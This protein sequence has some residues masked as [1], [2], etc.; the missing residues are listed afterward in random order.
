MKA[1]S[2]PSLILITF[3]SFIL[4]SCSKEPNNGPRDGI[5]NKNLSGFILHQYTSEVKKLD[6]VTGKESNFFSYNSY[7]AVGWD[8]SRDGTVRI[9]A[10]REPGVF[11]RTRMRLV[12]VA[13]G[14]IIKDFDYDPKYGTSTSNMGELSFDKT[15][16]LIEPDFDNGIVIIN[17]DGE[18]LSRLDGINNQSFT[19]YDKVT[20]LPNNGILIRFDDRF[21]L[22]ADPPYNSL[23]L[24]KEMNYESWGNLRVSND[25]TKVSMYI[26]KHVYIMDIDGS[27]LTQVT[28][29]DGDEAF[30]EFS[31]DDRYLLIGADYFH[32]PA[33]NNSHWYL[34]IIPADGKKYN[35]NTDS[36]VIPVIPSGGSSIIRANRLTRWRP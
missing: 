36:E 27:N 28:E 15:L 14:T 24:V 22:R 16:I 3:I 31:P 5:S 10:E 12:K 2:S 11:D 30:G 26:N 13:D 18:E 9:M 32:A 6:A 17:T 4:T 29:S 8:V 1:I 35:L 19:A 21:I 33:S 25:G 7:S 20:W 23:N 34:K